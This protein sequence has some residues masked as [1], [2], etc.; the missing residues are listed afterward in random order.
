MDSMKRSPTGYYFDEKILYLIRT[1]RHL[2]AFG[3]GFTVTFEAIDL[4]TLAT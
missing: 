1:N 3:V 2:M 4:F